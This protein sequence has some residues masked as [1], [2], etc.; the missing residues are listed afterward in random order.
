[1]FGSSKSSPNASPSTARPDAAGDVQLAADDVLPDAVDGVHVAL[2][3]GQRGD[4]RHARVHVGGAHRVADGLG[5]L[6]HRPCDW[7]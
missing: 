5:L 6:D 2:I 3:A 4:V 1:M 7:L